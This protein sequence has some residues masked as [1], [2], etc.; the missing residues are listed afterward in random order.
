MAVQFSWLK[1]ADISAWRSMF[2][3]H[4]KKDSVSSLF[5]GFRNLF[6]YAGTTNVG[7]REKIPECALTLI[8]EVY[9]N[10]ERLENQW[11]GA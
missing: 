3:V 4:K 1:A 2:R 5:G 7:R 10:L 8:S 9:V 6:L 11:N